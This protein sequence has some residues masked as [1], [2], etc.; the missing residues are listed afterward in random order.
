[1]NS[2]ELKTRLVDFAQRVGFD[3]C[4][5]AVC[6]PPAHSGEFVSWLNDGAHGEMSYMARGEEK[7]RD[8][9]KI[10]PGAKSIIVL[11]LNYFTE[12]GNRIAE[13]EKKGRIARYALGDDYHDVVDAKLRKIDNG[14]F[15]R[16]LFGARR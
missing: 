2:V 7:R 5:V 8:P 14:V 16:R 13:T 15:A 12:T 9:Q 3:A 6:N 4:R 11:A 1:M 10:L